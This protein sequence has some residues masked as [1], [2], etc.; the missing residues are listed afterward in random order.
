MEETVISVQKIQW[1]KAHGLKRHF[2]RKCL[3]PFCTFPVNAWERFVHLCINRQKSF[4]LSRDLLVAQTFWNYNPSKTIH[5]VG[6]RL[7]LQ[8]MV[9][10]VFSI[11]WHRGCQISLIRNAVINRREPNVLITASHLYSNHAEEFWGPDT[12]FWFFFIFVPLSKR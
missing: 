4:Q 5:V 10:G 6:R 7:L 1:N 12:D 9:Q 3:I 11:I 8:V 2:K